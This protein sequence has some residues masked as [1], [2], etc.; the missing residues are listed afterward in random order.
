MNNEKVTE[1]IYK[2]SHDCSE[3]LIINFENIQKVIGLL[4]EKENELTLKAEFLFEF[5]SFE[6]WVNKANKTNTS[7]SIYQ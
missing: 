3:G 6:Q 1:I 5:K 7:N 2:N 4:S